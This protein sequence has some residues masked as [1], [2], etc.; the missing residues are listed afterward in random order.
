MLCYIKIILML[1]YVK[2]V[3]ILFILEYFIPNGFIIMEYVH[4]IIVYQ[5]RFKIVVN[6][7]ILISCTLCEM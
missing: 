6:S 5:T 7:C 4:H 2:I 1:F 3:F